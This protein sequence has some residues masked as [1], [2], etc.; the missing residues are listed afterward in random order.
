MIYNF[1]I[2]KQL[3]VIVY[4]LISF[5]ILQSCKKQDNKSIYNPKAIEMNNK[6]IKY[7]Q[8]FKKD[9]ALILY[10]K[11]IELD[12]TYYFPHSNKIN[13]YVERKQFDKAIYES[14][15]AIK[16]KP[17][18]AEGWVLSG[19]LY[20]KQGKTKKAKQHYKKSIKIFGDRIA[21]TDKSDIIFNNRLN[22][23]FSY[24]LLGQA[25][26]GKTELNLLKQQ[27]PKNIIIDVFLN[28]NK[29]EYINQI[30]G[31]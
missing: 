21:N 29:E 16:K 22:R 8:E 17:D 14:E 27:K 24:I 3:N 30:F 1:K 28:I 6:A 4:L 9:S 10:D 26:K 25:K 13:I 20:D 18:L 5:I 2:S 19:M 23:A 11:A 12:E 15:M 7:A 31:K